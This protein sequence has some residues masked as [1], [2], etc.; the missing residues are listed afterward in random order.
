MDGISCCFWVLLRFLFDGRIDK[1]VKFFRIGALRFKL[2][3]M[4]G[5]GGLGHE[6]LLLFL[7]LFADGDCI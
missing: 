2:S 5:L 1:E 7:N 6:I 4:V 3:F